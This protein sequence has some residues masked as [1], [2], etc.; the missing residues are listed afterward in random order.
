MTIKLTNPGFDYNFYFEVPTMSKL[1]L[2]IMTLS[3]SLYGQTEIPAPP[4]TKEW[5]SVIVTSRII[6]DFDR[7]GSNDI[8]CLWYGRDNSGACYMFSV[9]SYKKSVHLLTI[10]SEPGITYESIDEVVGGD[11]N[12]DEKVEL[13][14]RNKIYEYSSTLSKKNSPD[15]SAGCRGGISSR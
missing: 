6:G 3:I 5:T 4:E 13:I 8:L 1:F 11:I 2:A 12:N 14:Y 7:D 9:Y 10:P 15:N